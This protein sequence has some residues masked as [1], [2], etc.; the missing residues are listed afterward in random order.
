MSMPAL[1]S[2]T[3]RSGVTGKAPTDI[4]RLSVSRRWRSSSKPVDPYLSMTHTI[5]QIE[6]EERRQE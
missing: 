6:M 1:K 2:P 5:Y 3:P 4:A